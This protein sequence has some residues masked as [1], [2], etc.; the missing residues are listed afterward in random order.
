MYISKHVNDEQHWLSQ[1]GQQQLWN[2]QEVYK[3]RYMAW[4]HDTITLH[5]I[6]NRLLP[7]VSFPLVASDMFSFGIHR[8][9][10]RPTIILG[11]FT[12]E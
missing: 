7:F 2:T 9:Y 5:D 6:K 4:Q 1:G 3:L 10:V 11:I 8:D 12:I